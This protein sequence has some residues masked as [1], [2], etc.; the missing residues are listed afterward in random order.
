M[1]NK[2]LEGSHKVDLEGEITV[3]MHPFFGIHAKAKILNWLILAAG[4]TIG[5]PG[6]TELAKFLVKV[7]E[8][9]AKGYDGKH[10]GASA[11]INIDFTVGAEIKGDV[12]WKKQFGASWQT[13]GEIKGEIPL[14][15]KGYAEG[16]VRIFSLKACAGVKAGSKT[17]IGVKFKAGQDESCPNVHCQFYFNGLIVYYAV[18]SHIGKNSS[19]QGSKSWGA[20]P[21]KEV[22]TKDME[23]T[24][25]Y[26]L[27]DSAV[28]PSEP[29]VIA[30]N[31]G[32]L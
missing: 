8:K 7:K 24:H 21:K 19:K 14:E 15:L 9:A 18:Y 28:W 3:G 11:D 29:K 12:S 23:Y 17:A 5:G 4:T 20:S 10:V 31:T 22:K 32:A 27:F 1:R 6:G 13:N 26:K 2:E 30:L 16:T 25:Q